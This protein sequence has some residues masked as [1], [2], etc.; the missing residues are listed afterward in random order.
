M[1]HLQIEQ[2]LSLL[3]LQSTTFKQNPQNILTNLQNKVKR[4]LARYNP[5]ASTTDQPT[6]RAPNES[7]RPFYAKNPSFYRRKQKYWYPHNGKH[8]GN[9]YAL[10]FGR[11][12]D[13]MGQKCQFWANFGHFW[14]PNP[15]FWGQ[16]VKILVPS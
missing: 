8:L 9:L 10:F 3:L 14:A 5:R 4:C 1:L 12:L 2:T 11:A 16:E 13:Q 15:I 6:N 7:A